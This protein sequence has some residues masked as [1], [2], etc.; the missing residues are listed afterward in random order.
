MKIIGL[1][2]NSIKSAR[3]KSVKIKK[4]KNSVKTDI[5]SVRENKKKIS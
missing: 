1:I 4:K 3:S 5:S 2:S